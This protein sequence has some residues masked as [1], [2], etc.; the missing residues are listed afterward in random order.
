M[1]IKNKLAQIRSRMPYNCP[2]NRLTRMVGKAVLWLKRERRRVIKITLVAVGIPF[3]MLYMIPW[4]TGSLII[5]AANIKASDPD[6]V[7]IDRQKEKLRGEIR[8]LDRR[9]AS[10][11]G[12]LPYLV[13]NT[14]DNTFRLYVNRKLSREGICS[15]GS[16]VL[17]RNGDHQQ[18]MFETP[19]GFFRV[20]SKTTSPVW[21]KPDWAFV[22]EGLPVPPPG[23]S[24][25]FEYGVLGDYALGLGDGYLIHGTL[26]QRF[27]GLPVTHGCVRMKDDDLKAVYMAMSIGSRVYIY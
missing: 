19:K 13:I 17:L 5:P 25:R 15:T 6:N 14:S 12:N 2:V 9:L 8:S 27:L 20:Q 1:D 22:E 23:H 11:T 10:R 18:W 21:K 24:S 3:V 7:L 4:I 26:Y 16:F